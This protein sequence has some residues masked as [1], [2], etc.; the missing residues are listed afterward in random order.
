MEDVLI[1]PGMGSDCVA[2]AALSKRFFPY[3]HLSA[4][5]IYDRIKSGVQYFVLEKDATLLGFVD[6]EYYDASPARHQTDSPAIEGK[7]VKI[8]GLCV[9]ESLQGK[10]FGKKLLDAVLHEAKKSCGQAVILV[11]ESNSKAIFLY[12]RAGF[13]KHGKLQQKLWGKEI[14]LYVKPL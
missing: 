11:E 8:L 5:A 4:D 6:F 1:R 13:K 2:L 9:D 3:I 12:Q 14:L 7:S 10:G